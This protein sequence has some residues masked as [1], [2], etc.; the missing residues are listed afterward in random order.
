MDVATAKSKIADALNLIHEWIIPKGCAANK[1]NNLN[2]ETLIPLYLFEMKV[3]TPADIEKVYKNPNS[4][5][6]GMMAHLPKRVTH[7]NATAATPVNNADKKY[8]IN[9]FREVYTNAINLGVVG[10]AS[11]VLDRLRN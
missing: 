11:S 6:N 8:A 3:C 1:Y 10:S 4:F 7:T 9:V 2:F 5:I